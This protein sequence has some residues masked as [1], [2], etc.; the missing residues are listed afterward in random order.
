MSRATTATHALVVAHA[1]V[2]GPKK[3]LPTA[4]AMNLVREVREDPAR[5][6]VVLLVPDMTSHL[7]NVE[8]SCLE[9]EMFAQER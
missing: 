5:S 1:A 3:P 7:L 4:N 9:I 8:E 6:E 2:I